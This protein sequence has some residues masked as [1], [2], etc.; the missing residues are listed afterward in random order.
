[1]TTSRFP[2]RPSLDSLRH[3]AKRLARR[4]SCGDR[5]AMDRARAHMEHLKTPFPLRDAQFVVA[6]EYGFVSWPE[7]LKETKQRLDRELQWAVPEARRMIHEN[8]P[9]DLRRLL[10]EYPALVSWREDETDDGLL[11]LAT[12]SYGDSFDTVSEQHFTRAACTEVLLDA[13]APVSP[14]I[15]DGLI[16]ARARVLVDLFHRRGLLPRTLK[17]FAAMG[18]SEQVRAR[19]ATHADD[20][21]AVNEALMYAFHLQH[22]EAAELLLDR[23]MELDAGLGRRI[24]HGPGRS[25]FVQ[26]FLANK[27][28]VHRDRSFV[29][30]RSYLKQQLSRTLHEGELK[31]FI[32]GLQREAWLLSDEEVEFQVRLIEEA[33][34]Q[35][36][37]AFI[38]ALFDLDAAVLHRHNPPP[39]PAIEFAFTYVK[40]HLLPLLERIWPLPDDLPHAAGS[41]DL[42]RVRG[43]FDADGRPALGDLAN[44]NPIS[45]ARLC[46]DYFRWF[47]EHP[48]EQRVLDTALAWAVLHQH[49]EVADFLLAH[50]AD[51]D[52]N[53]SS[54]EPA[55]I[56]HE[57]VWHK[58]YRAMQFLI[59][60]GI[61]L[62]IRDFRWNATA[63]GW[64]RHAAK[65]EE[66][67]AFLGGAGR[68]RSPEL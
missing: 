10:T 6:R 11:S 42:P 39:S 2:D 63:E 35:D 4:V 1:M 22:A 13:G 65:D 55:S 68:R 9:E 67:A 28:D 31:A 5:D 62:T 24:G 18:D 43:W 36:R 26:F 59:D 41:G 60:R 40:A 30:W 61:D 52:T 14:A 33:V 32:D 66:L 53:W 51:I 3:Q 34:L 25:T 20:A 50:G 19:L 49:F 44:H 8:R 56:L 47:G 7:L 12:G 37:G 64:A 45:N 58:N 46:A 29:P 27:P 38:S 48:G 54:H 15:C 21:G 17:F 57:L 16:A 23:S